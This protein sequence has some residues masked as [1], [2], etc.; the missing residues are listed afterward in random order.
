MTQT[1]ARPAQPATKA[2][3]GSLGAL[4]GSWLLSLRA[5]NKSAK[6][7]TTY[8]ESADQLLAFLTERAMPTDVSALRREHVEAF[9]VDLMERRSPA[10]VSVRFRALQVMFRWLLDEGEVERNPM[11]R[12]SRPIIPEQPVAVLTDVQMRALL[13]TCKGKDFESRRDAAIITLFID[14]GMRRAE[15]AGLTVDD[16]DV[17][18]GT[19]TVLGKGRR[20]R[21]CKFGT[22]AAQ[23]LDRYLRVRRRHRHAQS[24]ALWLGD[25]GKL[26]DSGIA[27]LVH[28]RG[29]QAGIELHPHMLRHLFAHSWLSNGGNES[30]LMRLAGWRSRQ[31]LQRYASAT[32]DD[33]AREAHRNFSPMD[34]L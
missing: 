30:D 1:Q 15:L 24:S 19:A 27:Q 21:T 14:S 11:E 17:G 25:R 31:M 22:R 10:T 32:A 20:P 26:T 34:R 13:D 3:P 23:A 9:I 5:G 12:M 4:I 28:R 2:D 6:T 18:A 33:R 16:V 29:A 7:I 8:K